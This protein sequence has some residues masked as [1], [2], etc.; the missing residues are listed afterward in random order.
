MIFKQ[1]KNVFE[2]LP[3]ITY[4]SNRG[5]EYKK[6]TLTIGWLNLAVMFNI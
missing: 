3:A 6:G 1:Q 5:G 4:Y 2:F